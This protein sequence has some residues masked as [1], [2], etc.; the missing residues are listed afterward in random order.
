MPMQRCPMG[1]IDGCIL[2]LNELLHSEMRPLLS[3]DDG[4]TYQA[5]N[6]NHSL[7]IQLDDA[8]KPV[9]KVQNDMVIVFNTNKPRDQLTCTACMHVSYSVMTFV[10]HFVQQI[11]T[12]TDIDDDPHTKVC[13]NY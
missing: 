8:D 5:T 3:D 1:G 12:Q 2:L 10:A 7:S 13:Y 11:S 9:R 6:N 4:S